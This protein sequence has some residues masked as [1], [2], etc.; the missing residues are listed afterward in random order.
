MGFE[1][2]HYTLGY[3]RLKSYFLYWLTFFLLSDTFKQEIGLKM[4]VG[5]FK[6]FTQMV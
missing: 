6:V 3:E 5:N 4:Q 1:M 2:N